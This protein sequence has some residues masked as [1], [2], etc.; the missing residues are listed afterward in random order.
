MGS[1]ERGSTH[2][3]FPS[4][5]PDFHLESINKGCGHGT[6]SIFDEDKVA[7]RFPGILN[8]STAGKPNWFKLQ[9][10]Y[11]FRFEVL[12]DHISEFIR[13]HAI[14]FFDRRCRVWR[15][16]NDTRRDRK[17]LRR[18]EVNPPSM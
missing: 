11:D 16:F 3:R 15:F 4:K 7:Y 9:A 1:Y 14:P 12:Q 18:F 2:D 6:Y 5:H 13:V 10:F 17:Q 8:F